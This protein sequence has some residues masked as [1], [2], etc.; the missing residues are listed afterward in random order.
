MHDNLVYKTTEQQT[1]EILDIKI[2]KIY[3]TNNYPHLKCS[4]KGINYS[5]ISKRSELHKL[6]VTNE[7]ENSKIVQPR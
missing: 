6:T 1:T 4:R 5:K 2:T 7:R 3:K